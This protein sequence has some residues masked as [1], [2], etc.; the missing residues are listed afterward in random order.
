MGTL[1]PL[2]IWST[3]ALGSP[4]VLPLSIEAAEVTLYV[5]VLIL[6][7][8]TMMVGCFC[9]RWFSKDTC[10]THPKRPSG[11]R[12]TYSTTFYMYCI[13]SL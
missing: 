1:R 4:F 6:A 3:C 2:T 8:Q 13:E 9:Y 11:A 5:P 10:P 7:V 12:V